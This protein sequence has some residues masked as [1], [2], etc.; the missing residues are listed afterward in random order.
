MQL[1]EIIII[2]QLLRLYYF[3]AA[4]AKHKQRFSNT[5]FL[6]M[7]SKDKYTDPGLRDQVKEEIHNSDRGGA[8][9]QW[10]ARKACLLPS[11]SMSWYLTLA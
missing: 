9:G 10:S 1:R 2:F 5:A 4:G 11:A 3:V 7:P 6:M 8:P